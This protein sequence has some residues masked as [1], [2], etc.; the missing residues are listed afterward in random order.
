[1]NPQLVRWFLIVSALLST[2]SAPGV[3]SPAASEALPFSKLQWPQTLSAAPTAQAWRA[4]QPLALLRISGVRA[5]HCNA[6][7]VRE[8]L[9]VTCPEL[10]TS[11][12]TELS[13][14]VTR[15]VK[16]FSK[17]AA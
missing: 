12:I 6:R 5:T 3:P 2:Q 11:A 17:K 15:L 4:A 9:K 1:M 10:R 8:W 16:Q 7:A 13:P 14:T